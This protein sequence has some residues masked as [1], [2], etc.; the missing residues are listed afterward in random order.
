MRRVREKAET[1]KQKETN[2]PTQQTK[3]QTNQKDQ[4]DLL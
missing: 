4:S 2:N 3:Q 1:N